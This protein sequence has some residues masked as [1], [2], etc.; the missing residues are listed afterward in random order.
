MGI[1]KQADAGHDNFVCGLFPR[2][3]LFGGFIAIFGYK[4]LAHV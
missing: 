4:Y 3:I 1:M 2:K